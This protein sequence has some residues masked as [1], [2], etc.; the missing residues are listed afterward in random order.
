MTHRT[1]KVAP[2]SVIGRATKP[3][4]LTHPS[5]ATGPVPAHSCDAYAATPPK[6]TETFCSVKDDEKLHGAVD[7]VVRLLRDGDAVGCSLIVSP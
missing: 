3:D 1:S 4:A 7:D 6:R 2:L 5:D